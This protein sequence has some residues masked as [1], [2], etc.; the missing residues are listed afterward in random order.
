M[1]KVN[2]IQAQKFLKGMDYPASKEDLVKH[3][4]KQGADENVRS[5]LE[6]LPEEQYE[7]PADVSQ[8]LGKI[9]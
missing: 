9:E 4:E 5:A 2:P 7:T 8:A 3:A 1:A 6:Q